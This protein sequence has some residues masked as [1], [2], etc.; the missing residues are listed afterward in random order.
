MI[1][2]PFRRE[3][4]YAFP[5]IYSLTGFVIMSIRSVPR[6]MSEWPCVPGSVLFPRTSYWLAT[7]GKLFTPPGVA[8]EGDFQASYPSSRSVQS[9]SRSQKEE[10][11]LLLANLL[12][13]RNPSKARRSALR[14]VSAHQKY[15][16]YVD[17][18]LEW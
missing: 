16:Q 6:Q 18:V 2:P 10:E 15:I 14:A 7:T 3:C 4:V 12:T 11:F 17:A 8:S 5:G 1:F 9:Q 13:F